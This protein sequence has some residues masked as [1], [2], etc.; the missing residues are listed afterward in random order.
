MVAVLANI[1]KRACKGP[2]R[3]TIQATVCMKYRVDWAATLDM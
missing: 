3:A 1:Y 2:Y